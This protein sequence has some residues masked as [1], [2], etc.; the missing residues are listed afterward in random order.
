MGSLMI[1][2]LIN[3]CRVQGWKNFEN[4]PIFAKVISN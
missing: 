4:R 1:S 3:H 2:S